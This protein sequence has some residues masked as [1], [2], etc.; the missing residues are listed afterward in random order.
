[1]RVKLLKRNWLRTTAFFLIF[2]MVTGYALLAYSSD[3]SSGSVPVPSSV[4]VD[5]ARDTI[6]DAGVYKGIHL[7]HERF[8]ELMGY[9]AGKK[10]VPRK[11]NL[12]EEQE[13]LK[14]MVNQT[15]GKIQKDLDILF[16]VIEKA[17]SEND[18]EGFYIAHRIL[19]DLDIEL[20]GYEGDARYWGYTVSFHDSS[21]G[22][23]FLAK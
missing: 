2:I 22:S 15:S 17:K 10:V 5:A 13:R 20:N 8:N 21:A 6:T 19:H 4:T 1:M 18:R 9:G 11:V 16:N 23:D 3:G 7:L 14:E 12:G